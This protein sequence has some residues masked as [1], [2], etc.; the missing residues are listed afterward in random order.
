VTDEDVDELRELVDAGS[1]EKAAD[2]GDPRVPPPGHRGRDSGDVPH[3][4]DLDDGEKL[5]APSD[6]LL[7]EEAE[8]SRVDRRD[9]EREEDEPA[10]QEEA[11]GGDDDVK[12]PLE[13][14]VMPP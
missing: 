8:P 3:R 5:A 6:P 9:E 14:G 4:S 2:P 7:G 1:A 10:A 11:D 12:R 13:N